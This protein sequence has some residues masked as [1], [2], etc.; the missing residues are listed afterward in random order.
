MVL[1]L[2]WYK[3]KLMLQL[4]DFKCNLHGNHKENRY[5]IHTKANEL[6]ISTFHYQKATKY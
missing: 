3:F 4:L 2:N 5:R 6:G 1:K